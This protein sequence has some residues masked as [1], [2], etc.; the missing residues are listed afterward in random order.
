MKKEKKAVLQIFL[1]LFCM[2]AVLLTSSI[3]FYLS[4]K[5]TNRQ[6]AAK[7]DQMLEQYVAQQ[8]AYMDTVLQER[9]H[10][11]EVIASSLEKPQADGKNIVSA[12]K[13]SNIL[14]SGY[15]D[16]ILADS[17]GAGITGDGVQV[18]IGE[19]EYFLSALSGENAISAP[20]VS[21]SGKSDIR[22]ILAVPVGLVLYNLYKSGL[23]DTTIDSI[24]I[25]A[26][27][28]SAFCKYTKQDY[29]HYKKYEKPEK[30]TD[31]DCK[32]E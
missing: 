3:V 30:K 21:P 1:L 32:K 24:K 15:L 14:S 18:H 22:M 2:L 19:E 10:T 6:A 13:N 28:L 9:F 17:Q 16:F 25:L 4:N 12:L 8:T 7:T 11:L 27:D 5:H 23:F 31:G 29:V 20:F 26:R